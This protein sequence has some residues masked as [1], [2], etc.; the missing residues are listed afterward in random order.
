MNDRNA[1]EREGP[2]RRDP[3]HSLEIHLSTH[4]APEAHTSA[5]TG[6]IQNRVSLNVIAELLSEF[7]GTMGNFRM[8]RN[9]LKI[10]E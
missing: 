4:N 6:W 1:V 5:E 9:K 7:D 3:I 8:W 2:P 10:L